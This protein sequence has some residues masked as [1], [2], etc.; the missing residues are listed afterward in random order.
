MS[1]TLD[2]DVVSS[3]VREFLCDALRQ[4]VGVD[5][6][7]FALGMASSMF[8]LELIVYIE[9]RYALTLGSEDLTRVNFSSASAMTELI[10]R[11][12]LPAADA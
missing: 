8:A 12:S 7:I 2:A 6:D 11:R 4:P 1:S 10:L 9:S 5:D 3:D